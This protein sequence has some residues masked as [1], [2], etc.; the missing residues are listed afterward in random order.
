MSLAKHA[1]FVVASLVL[2]G[3]AQAQVKGMTKPMPA[4]SAAP[5][6]MPAPVM[7]PN[8]GTAP[9]PITS[10]PSVAPG[11]PVAAPAAAPEATGAIPATAPTAMILGCPDEPDCPPEPE[12]LGDADKEMLKEFAKCAAEGKSLDT[13]LSDD[14]PLAL[15]QL[16]EEDRAQLVQCL[17]SSD[18]SSTKERWSGCL[19]GAD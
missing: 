7:A 1:A 5:M 19:V 10:A 18:L 3:H 17:G 2:S 14:P 6:A 9:S 11:V 15:S 16:T 8:L 13:C 4:A 12:G